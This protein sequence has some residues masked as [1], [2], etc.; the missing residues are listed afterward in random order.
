MDSC[1][2]CRAICAFETAIL[3]SYKF[4]FLLSRHT[5]TLA[6]NR[7]QVPPA[8]LIQQARSVLGEQHA[9]SISLLQPGTPAWTTRNECWTEWALWRRVREFRQT[10][11]E[12]QLIHLL[13]SDATISASKVAKE[14]P[15]AWTA[16]GGVDDSFKKI[17]QRRVV[18]IF[19]AV[20][21]VVLTGMVMPGRTP[22]TTL[23][24]SLPK[25]SLEMSAPPSTAPIFVDTKEC[26]TSV[27]YP[28]M[29]LMA[30]GITILGASHENNVVFKV[31][32]KLQSQDAYQKFV[33]NVHQRASTTQNR[34]K[35]WT[36]ESE[37]AVDT[38]IHKFAQDWTL[39]I[40]RSKALMQALVCIL[41]SHLS[42]VKGHSLQ[43]LTNF[44]SILEKDWMA[45]TNWAVVLFGLLMQTS[46]KW[47][48]FLKND[49]FGIL[50]QALKQAPKGFQNVLM[51]Q[52]WA[53][54]AEKSLTRREPIAFPRPSWLSDLRNEHFE[55]LWWKNLANE[56]FKTL[57]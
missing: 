40:Q 22:S 41:A 17:R 8:T 33:Q 9:N 15:L 26:T 54:Q 38:V 28:W 4:I 34:I 16:I 21:L 2:F 51:E 56:D 3:S 18:L 46:G 47:W 55:P 42:Q 14:Y 50:E 43:F 7:K 12:D 53:L 31:H 32:S 39:I 35:T 37:L 44:S 10:G 57:W 49:S 19:G 25:I 52:S 23:P 45:V 24:R 29:D 1:S 36:K 27:S 6:L 30:P 20:C 48:F 11:E 5:H 13:E